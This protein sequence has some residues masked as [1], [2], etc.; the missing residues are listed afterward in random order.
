MAKTAEIKIV[1]DNKIG[2]LTSNLIVGGQY[3]GQQEKIVGSQGLSFQDQVLRLLVLLHSKLT[4]S[5]L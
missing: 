1:M 4:L 2:S 3:V 5:S